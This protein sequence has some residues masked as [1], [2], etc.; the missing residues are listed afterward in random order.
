MVTRNPGL[1]LQDKLLY[2]GAHSRPMEIGKK[3]M[4]CARDISMTPNFERVELSKQQGSKV[5]ILRNNQ[6]LRNRSSPS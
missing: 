4:K 1:T 5:S 2:I 6:L 3:T